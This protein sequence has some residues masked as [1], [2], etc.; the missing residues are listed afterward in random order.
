M[1]MGSFLYMKPILKNLGI[2]LLLAGPIVTKSQ[3]TQKH[4]LTVSEAEK[5]SIQLDSSISNGNPEILNHLIS[6]PVFVARMKSRSS[7]SNNF[8]T[9]IKI[10]D[11]YGL[12]N[13]GDRTVELVKNGSYHLLR[14]YKKDDEMHLLFRAFGDDGLNYQDI[15]LVKVKDSVK[16]ADIYSY[17]LGE[18]YTS[19][20]AALIADKEPQ[21]Q[22]MSLTA[23]DKYEGLFEMALSHKNYN[24]AK[25]AFE[26][27]DEQSQ[28]D[29]HLSLQYM[30]V[31]E[32]VDQKPYK[33]SIDHYASLFP[34]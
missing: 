13:I 8:D 9:L 19:I 4:P 18:P 29:K 11:A 3:A 26:K 2:V 6:F 28:N 25:S 34:E 1:P 10:A 20:F 24:A 5:L 27:L 32:H 30:Q 33:K 22:H 7:L 16:A 21:N 12:F 14:G 31:C 15:T 23:R 17:Q